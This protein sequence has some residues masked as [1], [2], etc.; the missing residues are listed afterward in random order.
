M[1]L[2]TFSIFI[3]YIYFVEFFLE[4]SHTLFI[5]PYLLMSSLPKNFDV[6]YTKTKSSCSCIG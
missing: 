5:I 2:L 6:S 4:Y 3:Y 1:K